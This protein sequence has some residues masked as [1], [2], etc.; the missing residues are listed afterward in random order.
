MDSRLQ[1]L[2]K[3]LDALPVNVSLLDEEGRILQTNDAWREFG[4]RNDIRMAADTI[5]INYL[6]VCE[7]SRTD[8]AR[9][10]RR[11]LSELL[12]GTRE[13]FQ[14]EYPC[15]SP[16]EQRWFLLV[17]VPVT[18]DGR[19]HAVVAH[20]NVTEYKLAA[21]QRER[22][23]AHL[24]ALRD[25]SAAIREVTHVIIDQSSR[26]EIERTV[27][28]ALVET[29]GYNCVWM[30]T[31]DGRSGAITVHTSAGDCGDTINGEFEGMLGET[32]VRQAIWTHQV[33][34]TTDTHEDPAFDWR[35]DADQAYSEQALAAV[36]IIHGGALYG[37]CCVY[38]DRST[39][40]GSDERAI[41]AQL[42]T[43]VGHAIAA[44]ER[45]R[46]LMSDELIEVD[47]LIPALFGQ[48][49]SATDWRI[50]I[51]QTV[52]TD[53]NYVMYGTTSAAEIDTITAVFEPL[54][55]ADLTVIS[56]TD[57]SRRIAI[58]LARQCVIP[59]LATH[60][61]STE[62]A[63]LENGDCSLTVHLP[64]SD[65]VRELIEVVREHH[66]DVELRA[67]RQIHVDPGTDAERAAS[68]LGDLTDRQRTVLQTAHAAGYFEWPRDASGEEV[69]E[70]LGIASPTFHQHLRVGQG[71]LMNA[72][73][74]ELPV[75]A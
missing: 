16:V 67:R 68:A 63:I 9:R 8:T 12:A 62:T 34:A 46:A 44:S 33:Q 65:T 32:I 25:L 15:H 50:E 52:A 13:E 60:G 45:T 56:G 24:E 54:D 2:G 73:F 75:T 71:K 28:S 3:S 70:T 74:E 10:A 43:V 37:I 61:W 69:A 64:S 11:G 42:G 59:L 40:F 22:Q 57:E 23:V 72:I 17:A 41:L 47:L 14:L 19:R 39:A 18:V 36:P 31:V 7:R 29:T 5:G 1:L 27:C 55:D 30:G 51:T 35:N 4:T 58:R 6:D 38:S 49:P 66:P 48:L 21:R 20:I 26:S 53:G